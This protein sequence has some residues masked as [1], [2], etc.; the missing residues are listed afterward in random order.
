MFKILKLN[1]IS[2]K[3]LEKFSQE[4]YEI[5]S[6][7]NNP[8]AIL[9]RSHDLPADD[10]PPSVKAISR[11]GVGVNNIPV[12]ACT[13]TGIPVFNTPGANANA[14]K[15]IVLAALILS[16]RGVVDGIEF[17]KG[18]HN[19][20]DS[21]K[22]K[23]LVE[24]EK[25]RFSGQEL[26]G[27]TLG[28]AG[29][30]K[31]GSLV[32]EMGLQLGMK[33][34]G[35]DPAISVEAAWRLSHETQRIENLPTLLSKSDYV[36]LH[37]PFWESTRH[38][39]N[40]NNIKFFKTGAR[41]LNFSRGEIVEPSAIV[42]ALD[43]G[44]LIRYATD[45]PE[46]EFFGRSDAI[47]MPHLGASTIEAEEMCAVMAANQLI[48]F[49]ENGNIKNS[50]NFPSLYLERNHGYRI[51]IT[52]KNVPKMLGKML[53]ILAERD[54]NVVEMLNRSRDGIAYN[55]IDIETQPTPE[56]LSTLGSVSGVINVRAL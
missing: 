1:H 48:D 37:L 38:L 10:I 54:I 32:A 26:F 49:L 41:L 46:P 3:G 30:G 21:G 22:L 53:A 50:V 23:A 33:V 34:I 31:I 40:H 43:N 4:R 25:K 28:V 24:G 45:F 15:E 16:S 20:T 7:F 6:E 29:L 36:S 12:S 55:I 27:K 17:V 35:Y 9:I 47:L 19:V 39:I 14:V 11:A 42:A 56:L 5:A 18:L 2:V 51:A 13:D 44:S 52:N 8:D